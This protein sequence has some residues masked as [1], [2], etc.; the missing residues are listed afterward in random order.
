[1]PSLRIVSVN[2]ERSKHLDRIVPFL[3][4]QNA[5]VVCIQECMERDVPL[6]EEIIGPKLIFT[7][8]CIFLARPPVEEEG[9]YAQAIFSRLPVR[10]RLEKYYAGEYEPLTLFGEDSEEMIARVARALSVVEIEKNGTIFKVATTHFTWSKNGEPTE[11]Q[12]RDLVT[13]FALLDE[14]K[15][16]VL[17]GDF[18][19]PR[20]RE[21]FD[22]LARKY[23]DNIPAHYTTSIDGDLHRAGQLSLMVDGLFTTRAYSATDVYLQDGISDHLGVSATINKVF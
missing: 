15:E 7:P 23:K 20:G 21:T 3:K 22:T 1:M 19:A 10:S 12:A 11:E 8:L 2:I 13:L 18:N 9:V 6:F 4:E 17:T 14:Q 5:D 16:F